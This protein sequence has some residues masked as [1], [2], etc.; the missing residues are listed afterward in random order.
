MSGVGWPVR[1]L[2]AGDLVIVIVF[3]T[4]VIVFATVSGPGHC[5]RQLLGRC[6]RERP[7]GRPCERALRAFPGSGCVSGGLLSLSVRVRS[8]RVGAEL[9]VVGSDT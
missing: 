5:E 4:A 9:G 6:R 7:R 2:C 1:C 8:P 3:I